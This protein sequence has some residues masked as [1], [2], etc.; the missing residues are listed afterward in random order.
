MNRTFGRRV[1]INFGSIQFK[2]KWC[3]WLINLVWDK[4][5]VLSEIG[6]AINAVCI[7]TTHGVKIWWSVVD[8]IRWTNKLFNEVP[9]KSRS[10]RYLAYQKMNGRFWF[11]YH[12]EKKIMKPYNNKKNPFLNNWNKN[13]SISIMLHWLSN[14]F[15]VS[16]NQPSLSPVEMRL[17]LQLSQWIAASEYWICDLFYSWVFSVSVCD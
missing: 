9:D 16:I 4:N 12:P 1:A 7:H 17:L 3:I 10:A 5:R 13:M 2:R 15:S 14:Y 11:M 8:P 6:T